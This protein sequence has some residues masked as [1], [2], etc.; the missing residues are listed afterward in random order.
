[1]SEFP[2]HHDSADDE[3]TE[4]H[5]VRFVEDAED[6]VNRN[7]DEEHERLRGA[8]GRGRRGCRQRQH[9]RADERAPAQG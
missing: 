4:G 1:M 3:S 2:I 8:V 5:K 6:A 7:I 9:R